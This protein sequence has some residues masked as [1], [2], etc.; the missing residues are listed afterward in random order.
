MRNRTRMAIV[1][2]LLWAAGASRAAQQAAKEATPA[3][4][5]RIRG[6]VVDAT[7]GAGVPGAELWTSGD[8][9]LRTVA[10]GQGRFVFEGLEEEKYP[11]NATAPGYVKEG[12]NQHGSFFTGIAVGAGVDSEHMVFKL[13]RQGV[14]YGRVTDDHGDGVRRATVI[15]FEEGVQFGKH[16]VTEQTQ[17]QTNDLGAYRFAHLRPGKYYVAVSARP[18]WAETGVKYQS[19]IQSEG[20]EG[21]QATLPASDPV[22]DVVYPLTYFAG[23]TE[24]YG[25]VPLTVKAGD[26]IEA[27]VGLTAV[28]SV[29]LLLANMDVY[30]RRGQGLNVFAAQ[31][32]FG[33]ASVSVI[34]LTMTDYGRGVYEVGGLPPGELRL[35][36]NRGGD[37]EWDT[38]GVRVDAADGETV[39]MASKPATSTVSGTV[40]AADGSKGEMQ[41]EA[42]LR[43]G[44]E[45]SASAR[46]GKDG[47]FRIPAVAEGTYEVQ[48]NTR[49]GG[50]YVAKVTGSGAKVSGKTVKIE[51]AG[52]VKLTVMLG[53]GLGRVQG[54]VK[55][56][57]KSTAGVM[58]L[59]VPEAATVSGEEFERLVR[60]DQSDSDGTFTLGGVVPG[61][62]VLMAIED[63]W[64]LEWRQES[65]L[66][67]YREKGMKVEVR[68]EEEKR[69]VV[70]GMEKVAVESR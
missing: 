46:L 45:E 13:H 21:R 2:V 32:P 48:V 18:W 47:T 44:D 16:G 31:R 70:E 6:V 56:G 37:A 61:K 39:D 64:E 27:N 36:V 5:Y 34:A 62:Y 12:L 30:K 14:I 22:F 60:M 15:L 7:T 41:G 25:A 20:G 55:I 8:V 4:S 3:A 57:E 17:V 1:M 58:V 49:T 40:L 66:A 28:P 43:S 26:S 19:K 63:G 23:A 11:L 51:G 10:D 53:R 54:V 29:H 69:L 65:V 9:E 52:E 68:A 42:V 33:A 38:H 50:D 67:P 24:E 35:T 59:M